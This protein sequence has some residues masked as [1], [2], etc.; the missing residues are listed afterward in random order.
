MQLLCRRPNHRKANIAMKF[1]RDPLFHFLL[2]GAVL[3]AA[4]GLWSKYVE[5]ADRALIVDTAEIN[6]QAGL[7]AIENGRPPNDAELNGIILA[8]VEEAVLA[9]E[10]RRLGLDHD[11]TVIRRRLA[12]KM[13]LVADT[14]SVSEP[15]QDELTDWFETHRAHYVTPELRTVQHVFFSDEGRSDPVADA[16]SADM[17]DWTRVGDP[18]IIARQLGPV[19]RT[20]LQQDYGGAF[21]DAAFDQTL[22]GEEPSLWS[23]PVRSPFGVHRVRTTAVTLRVEPAF[24]AVIDAVREDWRENARREASAQALRTMIARYDVVVEE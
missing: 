4:H 21:A 8:F 7:Y 9:R 3:F 19:S 11:D 16:A 17:S 14:T 1:T 5:R 12:Q 2:L 13:R 22:S 6:R 24:A 23:D 15:T 18:F 10:A 20:R